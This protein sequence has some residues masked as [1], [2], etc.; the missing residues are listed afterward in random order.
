[1]DD[2]RATGRWRRVLLRVVL[3]LAAAAGV[4]AL[5]WDSE[6]CSIR[7]RLLP[8]RPA[9]RP[10]PPARWPGVAP[11]RLFRSG[12]IDPH[13]VE[14]VLRDH[15]IGLVVDLTD[16]RCGSPER[17][18]EQCAVHRL[19]I[20][21]RCCPLKGDGTGEVQEYANAVVAI[22]R[23]Q[24]LERP[25]LVHCAAGDKRSGGVI[26]AYLLLV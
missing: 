12:W 7:D 13:L 6:Y 15:R 19:G 26:A 1:M 2:A 24:D 23:A 5:T 8:R 17:D 10:P 4:V 9:P 11:P 20:E 18:A 21:Y 14:D 3:P 16:A 25:V 22:A